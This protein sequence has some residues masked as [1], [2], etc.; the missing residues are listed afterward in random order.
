MQVARFYVSVARIVEHGRKGLQMRF[1][2]GTELQRRRL[3]LDKAF[4]GEELAGRRK[5]AAARSEVVAAGRQPIG[6]PPSIPLGRAPAIALSLAGTSLAALVLTRMTDDGFRMWS[7][8]V[9]L[10]VC[11]TYLVRWFWLVAVP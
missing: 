6:P 4:I 7:R 2:T 8:R 10:G 11:V 1:E 9:T 3:H 5:D